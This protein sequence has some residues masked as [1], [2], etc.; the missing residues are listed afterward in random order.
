MPKVSY[1]KVT[2]SAH[3]VEIKTTTGAIGNVEPPQSRMMLEIFV[4]A[5]ENPFTI[6]S[7]KM[8]QAALYSE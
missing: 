8:I 1:A 2:L 5:K 4:R 7:A 6:V 3:K